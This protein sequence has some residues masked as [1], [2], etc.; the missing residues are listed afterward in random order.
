MP[1]KLDITITPQH[2]RPLTLDV[3][4]PEIEGPLPLILFCHG[5]KGFKNWGHWSEIAHAFN[6]AGYAFVAMNFSHNGTTPDHPEEFVDLEAFGNNNY[7]LELEDIRTVV[8]WLDGSFENTTGYRM[9]NECFAL[10]GHSRGGVISILYASEEERITHL[11]TWASVAEADYAWKSPALLSQWK[12]NGVYHV[13]NART[14][15]EMP[16]YYQL[17]EDFDQHREEFDLEETLKSL[18][19]PYLVVHGTEDA[20]VPPESAERLHSWAP[21][22]SLEWIEGTGHVFGG[23]HPWEKEDLPEASVQLVERSVR[24]LNEH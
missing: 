19:I 2:G 21:N 6:E 9:D 22:S 3:Y 14:G 10:C 18:D 5:F 15:Q 11:I 12:E 4:W 7:S 13:Q 17:F 1:E 8:Q 16:M 24:F 20:G 23:S